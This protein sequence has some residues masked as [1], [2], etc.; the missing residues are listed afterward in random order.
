MSKGAFN[1]WCV[2]IHI[3][4]DGK[5]YVGRTGRPPE[6]RWAKGTGYKGAFREAIR[7]AGWEN[8]RHEILCVCQ[9]KAE[10]MEKEKEYIRSYKSFL[11]EH[12][13][14]IVI[15]DERTDELPPE[16]LERFRAAAPKYWLGKKRPPHVVEAV[17]NA[18]RNRSV[19]EETRRKLSDA[20]RGERNGF[21][22]KR[23]TEEFKERQRQ[24]AM[25]NQNRCNPVSQYSQTGEF[26]RQYSSVKEAAE[27]TGIK[28]KS[29][30]NCCSGVTKRAGGY[31][32]KH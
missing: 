14:N 1:Q 10:A 3:L 7:R 21:Y 13:Y 17:R 2:Y 30:V 31:I 26:L 5:V 8:I 27:I 32:W 16:V 25:G 20:Q 12:G 19:S 11:P 29:I 28:Y 4:P 15:G 23:H 22:G 6:I 9:T 18:N 24:R